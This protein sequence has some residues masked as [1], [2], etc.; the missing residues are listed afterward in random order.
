VCWLVSLSGVCGA[1]VGV[2]L[3]LLATSPDHKRD[4]IAPHGALGFCIDLLTAEGNVPYAG[5]CP[6]LNDALVRTIQT[7]Y[8][9]DS[10]MVRPRTAIQK[11][12]NR[13]E[14]ISIIHVGD[15]LTRRVRDGRRFLMV[16]RFRGCVPGGG[17]HGVSTC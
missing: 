12:A 2:Q 4:M 10:L 11:L 8:N 16:L 3:G 13:T 17:S 1:W 9:A 15:S 7:N 6:A 5:P 14:G